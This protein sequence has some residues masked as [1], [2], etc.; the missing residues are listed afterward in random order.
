MSSCTVSVVSMP[1]P[2]SSTRFLA[3]SKL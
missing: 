2:A 3:S 1:R